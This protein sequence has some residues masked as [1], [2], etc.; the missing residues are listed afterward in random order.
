MEYTHRILALRFKDDYLSTKKFILSDEGLEIQEPSYKTTIY[1]KSFQQVVEGRE[2]FLFLTNRKQ[3][4]IVPK[5]CLNNLMTV[6]RFS[7]LVGAYTEQ[8]VKKI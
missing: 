4:F 3:Y 1:W 8:P 2:S 7:E 5:R 6:E